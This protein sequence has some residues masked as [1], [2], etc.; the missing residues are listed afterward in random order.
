MQE[1]F[2]FPYVDVFKKYNDLLNSYEK[3]EDFYKILK[4]VKDYDESTYFH[5]L[6]VGYICGLI[7]FYSNIN[8]RDVLDLFWAGLLHDVGKLYVPLDILRKKGIL[9]REERRRIDAHCELGGMLLESLGVD[10]DIAEIV[11]NHHNYNSRSLSHCVVSVVDVTDAL[12]SKRC[13]KEPFDSSRAI[14]VLSEKFDC[15]L[16]REI[17]EIYIE[18]FDL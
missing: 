14:E 7:G 6:R 11:R 8:E 5:S 1:Y 2:S 18:L 12:F 10:C 3:N 4:Y 9:N 13:Y 17:V 16:A 15:E